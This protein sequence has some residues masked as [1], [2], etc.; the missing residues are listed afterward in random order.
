MDKEYIK[1]NME[2]I[3]LDLNG[4]EN[5]GYE[6][7]QVAIKIKMYSTRTVYQ[8]CRKILN[9]DLIVYLNKLEE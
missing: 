1:W 3:F 5:T 9:N 4:K 6:N 2:S 8:K 7:L